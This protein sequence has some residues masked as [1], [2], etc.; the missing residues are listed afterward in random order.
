MRNWANIE[1]QSSTGTMNSAFMHVGTQI[2]S[3][4]CRISEYKIFKKICPYSYFIYL[5]FVS[6]NNLPN[7]VLS[8]HNCILPS[9]QIYIYVEICFVFLPYL[10]GEET[11]GQ[12][13]KIICTLSALIINKNSS[14]SL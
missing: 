2:F 1:E 10:M 13:V 12:R 6:A 3:R 4:A 8:T 11:E 7:T 5:L 9:L 14:Q